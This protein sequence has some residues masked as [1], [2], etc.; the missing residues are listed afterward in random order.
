[1]HG[2]KI[3]NSQL[4]VET[5]PIFFFLLFVI[6]DM[7]SYETF[8]EAMRR[9]APNASALQQEKP[10]GRKKKR[11]EIIAQATA[12]PRVTRAPERQISLSPPPQ[13]R[14]SKK[15]EDE[16]D[17][18][19]EGGHVKPSSVPV[20]RQRS[21][22]YTMDKLKPRSIDNAVVKVKTNPSDKSLFSQRVVETP[23]IKPAKNRGGVS[24]NGVNGRPKSSEKAHKVL[25]PADPQVYWNLEEEMIF[26]KGRHVVYRVPIPNR[27]FIMFLA[28]VA[29]TIGV[30]RIAIE[31]YLA[32][33]EFAPSNVLDLKL[34]LGV[35]S[36]TSIMSSISRKK[37]YFFDISGGSLENKKR[38]N[39]QVWGGPYKPMETE[40]KFGIGEG[41]GLV[42]PFWPRNSLCRG[43][44]GLAKGPLPQCN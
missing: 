24:A 10:E 23:Q 11:D 39:F 41:P 7:S 12:K 32:S 1:M 26:E 28:F 14:T 6:L 40:A 15:R 2:K 44:V 27:C 4:A 38:L 17:Y 35:S 16:C 3:K 21:E 33:T 19:D 5:N 18:G 29:A 43:E 34:S 13:K 20:K 31:R 37:P 9:M 25:K 8:D 22:E 36:V 30:G 42:C